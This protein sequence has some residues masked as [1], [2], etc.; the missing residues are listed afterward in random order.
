M[1][2]LIQTTSTPSQNSTQ[3]PQNNQTYQNRNITAAK[4][5]NHTFHPTPVRS[6]I[7]S[8]RFIVPRNRTRVLSNVLFILS[9]RA[10]ESRISSPIATV[11]YAAYTGSLVRASFACG[12][13]DSFGWGGVG[14]LGK[15]RRESPYVFQHLHFRTHALE[16]RVVLALEFGQDRVAV[17]SSVE[18][19]T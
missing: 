18:R 3:P 19:G 11:I 7:R 1:Q 12:F 13:C 16:L 14:G 4:N 9:A 17:L 15:A 6:A 10:E 5:P 8:I 2:L